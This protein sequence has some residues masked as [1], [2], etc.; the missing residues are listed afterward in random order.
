MRERVEFDG[1][2]IIKDEASSQYGLHNPENELVL[3]CIMDDIT[4]YG[5]D[6]CVEGYDVIDFYSCVGALVCRKEGLYGFYIP[7]MDKLI[8]PQ[9]SSLNILATDY[10]EETGQEMGYVVYYSKWG[11]EYGYLD[12]NAEMVPCSYEE[13][14]FG[15]KIAEKELA[16]EIYHEQNDL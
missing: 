7:F 15:I 3:P 6:M 2:R 5:A 10:D 1:Y 13:S 4:P 16:W 8:E 11:K 12:E 9:F 14:A